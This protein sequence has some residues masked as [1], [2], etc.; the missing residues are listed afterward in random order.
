MRKITLWEEF[1]ETTFTVE[2]PDESFDVFLH[3]IQHTV[4]HGLYVEGTD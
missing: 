1:G 4:K 3:A 2:V